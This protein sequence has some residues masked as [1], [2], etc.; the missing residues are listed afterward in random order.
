MWKIDNAEAATVF[1]RQTGSMLRVSSW[2]DPA[3]LGPNGLESITQRG[4]DFKAP[5]GMFFDTGVLPQGERV[6]PHDVR[7]RILV[8]C[9]VAV[10]RA[11]VYDGNPSTQMIPPGYDSFYI[12]SKPLDRNNDGNFSLEEYHAAAHFDRREPS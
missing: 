1:E 9:E 11:F 6:P 2:Y 12:P 10:G 7:E 3:S 8:Y 4:F 5:G